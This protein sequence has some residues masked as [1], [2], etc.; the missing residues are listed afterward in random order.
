MK[1]VGNPAVRIL[2]ILIMI[3]IISSC[4][5]TPESLSDEEVNPIESEDIRFAEGTGDASK[6]SEPVTEPAE[7]ISEDYSETEVSKSKKEDSMDEPSS[8]ADKGLRSVDISLLDGD[9]LT[10]TEEDSSSGEGSPAS[11]SMRAT[12]A[13]PSTSGLKAG[14]SDDNRQFNY[15]VNFLEEYNSVPHLNLD[16]S[17][18]IIINVKDSNDLSIPNADVLI[19]SG[20]NVITQ[21]TT[22]A[23]GSFRFFPSLFSRDLKSFEVQVEDFSSGKKTGDQ[24]SREGRREIDLVI[25]TKRDLE[26][27]IPLDILFILDTTGSMG[28]EIQRLK[29]TIQLIH[30][31]LS[32]LSTKPHLRF[33][34]VLYKD[35]GDEEYRTQ[36][37]H[38]T[39]DLDRF[40]KEL[41]MVEAYGGGDTPEDLQAALEDSMKKIRWNKDGIRLA[42]IITD[43]PP[44]L[45]YGQEYDYA[46]ASVEAKER[47]IKIHSVGT[48]GLPL[49]GEYILRQISQFTSGRYIFLTYGE[50]GESEGGSAGSVSHHTGANF[51]TDKLE[52]IIIRFAKEELSYLSDKPLEADDPFFEANKIDTEKK[53]ETLDT[54]FG[55]AIEQLRDYSTYAVDSTTKAAVVPFNYNQEELSLEAEYFTERLILSS[56]SSDIFTL[57]E[58]KDIQKILEEQNLQLSGITEGEDAVKIG[59]I[60][61]A[62]VLITGNL[63]GMDNSFELFLRLVRVETGEILSIT[64]SVIDRKLGIR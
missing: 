24:F 26:E 51:Q 19:K 57:V 29:A 43:A 17:E 53:E 1:E 7:S 4:A 12:A 61:N 13:P 42:F 2:F 60:L 20:G 63:F 38:L 56:E 44:H 15:F 27:H 49:D 55:M 3:L 18:R 45:D 52:A 62:D 47:G 35:D 64:R 40:Q 41:N 28:E 23:D 33:G 36:I 8:S 25:N 10:F 32:S 30:L 59:Q 37:V 6:E 22:L 11:I 50:Q 14:Y 21:G 48:G 9:E 16:I 54:L 39:D 31:N 5:G 34:L 46:Q 58:R